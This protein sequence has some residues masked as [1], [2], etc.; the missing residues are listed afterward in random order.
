MS[1]NVEIVV[2]LMLSILILQIG[3][4]VAGLILV[5]DGGPVLFISARVK[6]PGCFFRM[7]KFRTMRST[8]NIGVT[9]GDKAAY[10]TW[11]GAYLRRSRL[12]ELPQI[13]N[14]IRGDM[15]FVG[16]RPPAPEYVAAEPD[17]YAKVLTA[18]PGVTGLATI[19]LHRRERALLARGE[20]AH[21]VDRIYRRR[22]LRIKAR[23]DLIY[24]RK[25][26]AGNDFWLMAM[27]F[28]AIY[29]LATGGR[30]WRRSCGHP[31]KPA[32]AYGW[33]RHPEISPMFREI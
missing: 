23:I 32:R 2:A 31:D 26:S 6:S 15:A 20:T 14:I 27:T 10:V 18:R 29:R 21:E 8:Q 33:A 22:C 25:K 9:G 16:P 3:I 4:L 19:V 12:D 17:L 1:R 30:L 24:R 5:I 11:L 13:I 28:V 7:I